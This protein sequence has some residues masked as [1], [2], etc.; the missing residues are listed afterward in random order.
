[1]EVSASALL[2]H[3]GNFR[4]FQVFPKPIHVRDGFKYRLA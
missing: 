1:M 2:V 4:R 3:I